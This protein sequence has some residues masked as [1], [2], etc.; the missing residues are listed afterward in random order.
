MFGIKELLS[1]E[2]ADKVWEVTNKHLKRKEMLPQSIL[3][4]IGAKI[5]FTTDDPADDLIYHKMANNIE[6]IT[7]LPTF[8]PDAYCHRFKMPPAPAGGVSL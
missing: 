2:T 8:R 5:I 3:K 6:G 1:D 4:K 7:F